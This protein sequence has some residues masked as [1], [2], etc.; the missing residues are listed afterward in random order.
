MCSSMKLINSIKLVI[1][2]ICTKDIV[3]SISSIIELFSIHMSVDNSIG[4]PFQVS[5]TTYYEAQ[6]GLRLSV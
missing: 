5:E 2:Y 1:K 3:A 4:K 6:D